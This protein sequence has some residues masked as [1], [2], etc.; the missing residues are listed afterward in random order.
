MDLERL[1]TIVFD[2]HIPPAVILVVVFASCIL[3]SFFPPWPTD[4]ISLYA[5]F[6]AGRGVIQERMAAIGYGE[7]SPQTSNA[8]ADGRRQNR[9]VTILLKAKAV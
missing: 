9:R 1:A 2:P 4:V 6:L 5:G 8:T 3:E 7:G